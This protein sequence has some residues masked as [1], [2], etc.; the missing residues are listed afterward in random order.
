[1]KKR[2]LLFKASATPSN[3]LSNY[4]V[5][6]HARKEGWNVQMIEYGVAREKRRQS[7]GTESVDVAWL[8]DFWHPDGVVVECAGRAPTL[9]LAAFGPTPVV[10]LD[11]FPEHVGRG[12]VCVHSD[13]ASIARTAARELM[14]PGVQ[15]FAFVPH[16]EDVVWSRQRGEAFARIVNMNGKR[17]H[18]LENMPGTRAVQTLVEQLQTLPRPCGVLAVNDEVARLVLTSCEA[19]EIDVPGDLAVIGV[20]N[21]AELCENAL[22][23]LSSIEIDYL[24]AGHLAM[25]LLADRMAHPTSNVASATFGVRT[26]VR[27]ASTRRVADS[28]ISAALE[29]IRREACTRITPTQVARAMGVSRRHADLLFTGAVGHTIFEEIRAVRIAR[30][31]EMLANPRQELAAIPDFCGYRTVSELCRDFRRCTGMSPGDWRKNANF[32]K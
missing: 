27:R 7:N 10:L 26:L 20:D 9:D 23:T 8:V 19:A 13:A 17:F 14:S 1:M 31:K 15:N 22:V 12:A 16:F 29:L 32:G 5:Y 11:C 3:R 28:R 21:D 6:Q 4:G 24:A 30:V 25:R 2:I 18:L